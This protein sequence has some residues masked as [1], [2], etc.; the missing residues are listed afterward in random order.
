MRWGSLLLLLEIAYSASFRNAVSEVASN[1][2]GLVRHIANRANA[3]SSVSS[4]PAGK[5]PLVIRPPS[6][7]A[8]KIID[9]T[10]LKMFRKICWTPYKKRGFEAGEQKRVSSPFMKS[11]AL[12][13]LFVVIAALGCK[14]GSEEPSTT[15]NTTPNPA[16]T[17]APQGSAAGS[18]VAAKEVFAAN[19][20][21]CHSG[22]GAKEGIDFSSYDGIMKGG[23]DGPVVMAGDPANSLVIKA[24]R[25]NGAKQMPPGKTIPEDKILAIEAWIKAGAKQD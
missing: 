17:G 4:R 8:S 14:S 10:W 20:I 2:C 21:G 22:P 15:D 1:P 13:S 18:F 6:E 16:S 23:H 19:C 24:L 9:E 12:A 5:L 25:G 7:L 11:L 3:S